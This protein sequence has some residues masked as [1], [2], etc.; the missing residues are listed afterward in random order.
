MVRVK[1]GYVAR[2]RRKKTL[3]RAKG[4][5]GSIGRLFRSAK[6][7]TLRS[8][9]FATR[10]RRD[11]KGVFRRLWIVRINAALKELGFTYNKF[12]NGLKKNKVVIDRKILAQL[13]VFD[14]KAFAR[15][16]EISKK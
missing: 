12:I 13:A 14:P 11:R 6:Q 4:F 16:V 3:A 8:M 10:D 9:K 5:R 15:I 7:A 1:R 2:R